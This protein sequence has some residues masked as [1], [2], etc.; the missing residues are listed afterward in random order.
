[1]SETALGRRLNVIGRQLTQR[2]FLL[3]AI[4]LLALL[5]AT[6]STL[7]STLQGVQ[8]QLQS[9]GGDAVSVFNSFMGSV[10]GDLL[11]TSAVLSLDVDPEQVFRLT[12]QRQIGIFE[13]VLLDAQ[14]NVLAQRRRVGAGRPIAFDEQPWLATV[15]IGGT[16]VGPVDY[17]E[18]GVPFVDM[19][20]GLFDES[21]NFTGTLVAKV[22]LTTLWEEAIGVQVG[23]TGYVYVIDRNGQLLIHP[24]LQKVLAGQTVQELIGRSPLQLSRT[25]L[26]YRGT[27]ES[28]VVGV[29][30][31][32]VEIVD[33]DILVEQPVGESLRPLVVPLVLAVIL[34]GAVGLIVF[35]TVR[36]SRQQIAVPLQVLQ[37]GVEALRR[38]NWGYRIDIQV[39]NEFG[40]LADTFNEMAV[41]I[42]EFIGSLE[43]RVADRTRNLLATAEVSRATISVLDIDQLLPQVVNLVRDRFD[44]YY[45][46]LF[47][48]D[49]TGDWTDD[50]PGR[51]AVLRAGT[52]EPGSEMLERRHK[53]EVGGTSMIGRCV[54]TGEPDIQLDVGETAVR[55][56]NPL[57]PDTRSEMAL[58]LRVRDQVIGAMTVQSAVESAFDEA[59]IAVMQTMVDQVAG[60][61]DNARSFTAAQSALARSEE[62]VR[63]YV[64]ETWSSFLEST[65][66][67]GYV[68][69]EGRG[70]ITDQVSG[71]AM[72]E[73]VQ[74]KDWAIVEE[75]QD[76]DA[77]AIASLAVPLLF[78]GEVIGT[79]CIRRTTEQ[80]WT[81]DE[82]ALA[83][84]VG[85]QVSQALETRRLF[86]QTQQSA[87]REALL[88]QTTDRVRSQASLES[89]LQTAV[90]EI[91]QAM[92]ATRVAIRLATAPPTE[93][94]PSEET[95]QEGA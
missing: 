52:G 66:I 34:A 37:E 45:V 86:E 62:I 13:L 93:A 40:D 89:L 92:G 9:V 23:E 4:S 3:S 72:R 14:G 38:E 1:M 46:G 2:V 26:P 42:Q 77:S 39:R 78:R 83:R 47:L 64:Q 63:S 48:V 94:A 19:A 49:E 10:Q 53:L 41:R 79:L 69:A 16:Y 59:D 60:A 36:F 67:P 25:F 17:L 15:E 54:E 65:Q 87:R 18:Y 8:G 29:S 70:R 80:P 24:E 27:R 20:V 71:V 44:L 81:D 12:L 32:L 95:V 7:A 31:P 88:R 11:S 43:Q 51:W 22:D 30:M 73:A 61:I 82:V 33:W 35:G 85:E 6:F 56:D 58:P 57:L 74:K 75:P 90:Q 28:L 50:R 55:F 68:Y 76:D 84:A 5:V 21:M 91:Q